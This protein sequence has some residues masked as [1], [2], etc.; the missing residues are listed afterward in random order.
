MSE[1]EDADACDEIFNFI[2]L[3]IKQLS[4]AEEHIDAM[5]KEIDELRQEI[6]VLKTLLPSQKYTYGID[7]N[8]SGY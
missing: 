6:T 8:A 7:S 2:D 4:K 3:K 5:Q 1:H